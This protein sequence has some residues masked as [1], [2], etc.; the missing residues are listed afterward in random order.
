M[1][2]DTTPEDKPTGSANNPAG[3]TGR[4]TISNTTGTIKLALIR[5]ASWLAMIFR[6]L[7]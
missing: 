3:Y 2:T 1:H 7:A 5:F 4:S 6:G